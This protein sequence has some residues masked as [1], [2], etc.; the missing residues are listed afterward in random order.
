VEL[1]ANFVRIKLGSHQSVWFKC[2]AII[3][4]QPGILL[5]FMQYAAADYEQIK[6]IAHKAA[7]CVL[8]RANDRLTAYIETGID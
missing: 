2:R 5:G 4:P 1:V 3:P 6:V 7:E 8:R